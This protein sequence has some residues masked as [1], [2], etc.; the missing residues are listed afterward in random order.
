MEIW[1]IG[2]FKHLLQEIVKKFSFVITIIWAHVISNNIYDYTIPQNSEY[3]SVFAFIDTYNEITNYNLKILSDSVDR[4][5]ILHKKYD[6]LGEFLATTNKIVDDYISFQK[7]E[8]SQLIM[9]KNQ[10]EEA[11]INLEQTATRFNN[12]FLTLNKRMDYLEKLTRYCGESKTII[13]D[14][15]TSF[16]VAYNKNNEEVMQNIEKMLSNLN[17]LA[18]KC[19][20]MQSFPKSYNNIISIYSGK[21][22]EILQSFEEKNSFM[23]RKIFQSHDDSIIGP[24]NINVC[25]K[26]VLPRRKEFCSKCGT[27]ITYAHT[28]CPQCGSSIYVEEM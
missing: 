3:K 24:K 14:I 18:Y 10:C 15:N 26:S 13:N 25:N 7:D 17:M 16:M 19:S 28:E 4:K 1:A 9:K 6:E 22:M 5:A 21:M 11:F 12:S 20:S 2:K 23:L 8:C 27:I